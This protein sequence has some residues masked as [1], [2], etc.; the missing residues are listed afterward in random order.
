VHRLGINIRPDCDCIAR[1]GADS[2]QVK[3]YLLRGS[4]ITNN[5][6]L[7]RCDSKYGTI[8]ESHAESVIFGLTG[9]TTVS[10]QF[11]D[12][13]MDNWGAW[14]D[15]RIG[16]LLP[17]FLTRLQQ[18]YAAYLQRPGLPRIPKAALPERGPVNSGAALPPT[19]PIPSAAKRVARKSLSKKR[20][21]KSKATRKKRT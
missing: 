9:G 19:S 21:V 18:R 16:R 5:K 2:D 7:E 4:R 11:K 15:D 12:L 14:K 8:R 3:L 13:L 20:A 10:F 6:V 1:E 17:P